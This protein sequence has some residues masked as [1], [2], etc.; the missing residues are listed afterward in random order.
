MADATTTNIPTTDPALL[1]AQAKAGQAGVDAYNAA[2]NTLQSQ[3]AT[4]V[5]SAMTATAARGIAEP[6][7][8]GDVGRMYD[9][10]IS[11]LQSGLGQF[12]ANTAARGQRL[13][14][15]NAAVGSARSLIPGQ[16]SMITAPI[17]AQGEYDVWKIG[18]QGR[19]DVDKINAQQ[20][21]IEA[22]IAAA[23]AAAA[24]GGGGGGGGRGGGGGGG[25]APK[26]TGAN[27]AAVI[28]D[29]ANQLTAAYAAPA[30]QAAQTAPSRQDAEMARQAA[31]Y[32][33]KAQAEYNAGQTGSGGRDLNTP[34]SRTGPPPTGQ[35]GFLSKLL[36]AFTNPLQQT[37]ASLQAGMPAAKQSDVNTYYRTGQK[38]GSTAAG[39]L[40]SNISTLQR[41]LAMLGG[42]RTPLGRPAP[43]T[44]GG[45]Y[46]PAGNYGDPQ[47]AA[48]SAMQQSLGVGPSYQFP[49]I[50]APAG[51]PWYSPPS[52]APGDEGGTVG[53]LE[54]I[55]AP[56]GVN[57]LATQGT[58]QF[59][60]QQA[61]AQQSLEEARNIGTSVYQAA[62]QQGA[63]LLRSSGA[64]NI[65]EADVTA[66]LAKLGGTTYDDIAREQ[67]GL[68]KA[69]SPQATIDKI[70]KD[71]T[72]AGNAQYTADQRT[73]SGVADQKKAGALADEQAFA[74]DWNGANLDKVASAAGQNRDWVLQF[75]S[76]PTRKNDVQQL[77]ATV[78]KDFDPAWKATDLNKYVTNLVKQNMST[79]DPSVR[80]QY[81]NILRGL[82]SGAI[83]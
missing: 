17:K 39:N 60:E 22:Q 53:T 78:A 9:S 50:A 4:A 80:S 32:T 20:K 64:Y 63:D 36:S 56:L 57:P 35:T 28:K 54:S 13:A 15:Y 69:L 31:A 43:T 68:D 82:F 48:L 29:A 26:V 52:G 71:R 44:G 3:R 8:G 23:Q 76:D 51:S 11:Q 2:I 5:N 77:Y 46:R 6:G 24:K 67:Q 70:L 33:G 72:A 14:D 59:P 74:T 65:P 45:V 25:S 1:A 81:T 30:A 34:T 75:L 12:Q 83:G 16:V 41:A 49:K 79:A 40:Q 19:Q 58:M 62:G 37:L 38:P 7:A 73:A 42:I 18:A 10:R 21:L 55:L 61:A 66:S 47:Q 27:A